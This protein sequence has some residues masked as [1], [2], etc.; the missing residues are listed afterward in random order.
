MNSKTVKVVFELKENRTHTHRGVTYK[1]GEEAQV[2]ERD[3]E[4]LR[5]A[6]VIAGSGK[7]AAKS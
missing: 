7:A 6:G 5:R 4:G 1:N 3:V 2:A